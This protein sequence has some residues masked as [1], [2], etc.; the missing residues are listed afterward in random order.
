M[1]RIFVPAK[2]LALLGVCCGVSARAMTVEELQRK[3]AAQ[4]KITVIDIRQTAMFQRGHVPGA[5]NVPAALVPE[6]TLPPLG[7]VVVCAEG[8]GRDSAAAAVAALN[9]KPGITAE[10]LAGGFAAWES[11]LAATTIPKGLQPEDVTYITYDQLKKNTG[12]NLVLVDLRK[13]KLALA[14]SL[15]A[16]STESNPPPTDLHKEFPNAQITRSPFALPPARQSATAGSAGPLLVLIDNGDGTDAQQ[17]ARVLKANGVRRAVILAGGESIL[18]RGGRSG[19][20]RQGLVSGIQ[21]T[22]PAAIRR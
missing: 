21:T 5:I 3:F 4:E 1:H 16:Q 2:W 20:Q 14:G 11:A 6:K 15:A 8:L 17:T 7:Q 22:N 13:P 19:L 9:Q 10:A 18:A 12:D